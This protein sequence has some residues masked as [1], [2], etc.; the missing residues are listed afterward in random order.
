MGRAT[1]AAATGS[2][3]LSESAFFVAHCMH[4]DCFIDPT[5]RDSL[6]SVQTVR[7][8]MSQQLLRRVAVY[9]RSHISQVDEAQ[10]I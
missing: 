4:A 6:Q 1:E 9:D 5:P 7:Q 10:L 8:H 3:F 2:V